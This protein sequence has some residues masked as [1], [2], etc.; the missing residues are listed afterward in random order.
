MYHFLSDYTAKVAGTERGVTEPKA[1]FSACF[2]SPFLPLPPSAYA[3]L[4]GEKLD[5]HGTQ[6]W[7]VNT[8]WT[9]GAYGTGHRMELA[10]TRGMIDAMLGGELDDVETRRD[11]VFGLDIPVNVPG[12]PAPVLDPRQTWDDGDAYDAGAAKLAGMFRE[13]F[14]K[15]AANVSE[16]VR[17][18]GPKAG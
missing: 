15:Y 5:R 17:A 11:P 6:C 1:A 4:L 13:N 3:K 8:G 10:H 18:A 16:A 12:V 2:G 14:E 7:L 9:G